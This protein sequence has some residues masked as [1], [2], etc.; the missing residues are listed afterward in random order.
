MTILHQVH[1][2]LL[3]VL[4]LLVSVV[5]NS[6]NTEAGV[7]LSVTFMLSVYFIALSKSLKKLINLFFLSVVVTIFYMLLGA[8]NDA[9][10][11]A[12]IQT[13]IIYIV[14]PFFWIVIVA[15]MFNF[16]TLKTLIYWAKILTI[17]S[18]ISVAVFFYL[19]LNY[20]EESVLFFIKEPNINLQDGFSAA[21][22]HVYGSLIFFSGAFFSAPQIIK[23]Y[24]VRYTLLASLAICGLTSGRSALI[25]AMFIG[26]FIG[27]IHGEYGNIKN[28]KIASSWTTKM[29]SLFGIFLVGSIF[30][31]YITTISEI[32]FLVI[33]DNF[34]EKLLS[35]GGSERSEQA[36]ALAHSV[37]SS[38]GLGAGHGV[39]VSSLRSEEFPWRYE[40][41]WLATLHRVGIL[42]F[43]VYAIPFVFCASKFI[44]DWRRN[45]ISETD[46]FVFSGFLSALVASATNPYI[47]AF[48]FQWMYIVPLVY[49]LV[50]RIDLKYLSHVKK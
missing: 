46:L 13:S 27:I 40:L 41:I 28:I 49:F 42:G 25:I 44:A 8:S 39:G 15:V 31:F 36:E 16:F 1:G 37:R 4:F 32:N 38:F 18:V 12:I 50:Y 7:A 14:T 3:I 26:I 48:S 2:L 34:I 17:L 23:N 33:I 6:L 19:F 5:P 30:Y 45:S 11:I 24:A 43:I 47:E 22:L 35:G 10:F 9:P 29:F 20:G 21:T